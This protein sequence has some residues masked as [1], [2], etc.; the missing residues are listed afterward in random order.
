[1][2][3]YIIGDVVTIKLLPGERTIKGEICGT[4]DSMSSGHRY[5]ADVEVPTRWGGSYSDNPRCG[6]VHTIIICDSAKIIDRVKTNADKALTFYME[7]MDKFITYINKEFPGSRLTFE[8]FI[9]CYCNGN[10]EYKD[11]VWALHLR[12]KERENSERREKLYDNS[13]ETYLECLE[14]VMDNDDNCK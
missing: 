14:E 5:I 3:K 7:A 11:E 12:M 4:V 9:E 13:Y 10:K 2:D 6:R 8:E 1:M